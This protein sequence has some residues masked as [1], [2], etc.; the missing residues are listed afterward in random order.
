MPAP[1]TARIEKAGVYRARVAELA[2]APDS[3][4]H[5]QRFQKAA[6]GFK[7]GDKPIDSI[8]RNISSFMASVETR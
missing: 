1:A 4:F 3:G 5:F 7:K 2:D 8:D 6:L